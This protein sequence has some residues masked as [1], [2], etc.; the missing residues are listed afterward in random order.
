MAALCFQ[1]LQSNGFSC[2]YVAMKGQQLPASPSVPPLLSLLPPD[3]WGL[4][5]ASM[6]ALQTR[7]SSAFTHSLW[8][9]LGTP[10]L[11]P[12]LSD[13]LR[14]WNILQ[15][16]IRTPLAVPFHPKHTDLRL[17][18]TVSPY[19]SP[20]WVGG[21]CTDH[22]VHWTPRMV[23]S[24]LPEVSFWPGSDWSELFWGV[25]H[26]SSNCTATDLF[27]H[28]GV[29]GVWLLGGR[30]ACSPCLPGVCGSFPT[31]CQASGLQVRN[32]FIF[33]PRE[34]HLFFLAGSF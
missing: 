31:V 25:R 8:S 22:R 11:N 17:C 10:H 14:W 29:R 19:L 20:T 6:S 3:M 16:A 32:P 26:V 30:L 24:L 9:A 21:R 4:H 23:P 2:N 15:T 34:S 18:D 13:L 27:F 33:F 5:D 28:L 1:Y 12:R 7:A